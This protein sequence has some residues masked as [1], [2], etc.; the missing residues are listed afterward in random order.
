MTQETRAAT[1][2]RKWLS[3]T[4]LA[5]AGALGVAGC[6]SVPDAVNPVEWYRGASDAVGGMFGGD[7]PEAGA[8][9]GDPGTSA[10]TA[11]PNLATVPG[12]PTPSTTP[13]QREAL[14]QG[15][16]AD[17]AN[18][19]Y[20]EPVPGSQ[21]SRTAAAPQ[22]NQPQAQP[23]P[24]AAP[25]QQAASPP[26]ARSQ[27]TASTAAVPA[28]PPPATPPATPSAAVAPPAAPP[29]AVASA[30]AVRSAAANGGSG[31]WPNRPPP[32]TPGVRASTT[33]R[34]GGDEIHRSA[35]AGNQT[36]LPSH[37]PSPTAPSPSAPSVAN[38]LAERTTYDS[39][40][41]GTGSVAQTARAQPPVPPPAPSEPTPPRASEQSVIVN[42]DAIAGTVA[43]APLATS[44]GGRRYLAST[45]YFGHGSASI[46]AGERQEIARIARAAAAN[47]AAIQV[48]GHASARTADLSLRDHETANLA[49]SMKRAQTVA[50]VL[51]QS[52]MPANRVIVEAL[53][54]SQPEFYEV[55]PAGEAGNRRAEIIVIY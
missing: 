26:L 40:G 53:A 5:F 10:N 27:P 44:F 12:R 13:E 22:R 33:G 35:A 21:A 24:P 16:V 36:P 1:T 31:L 4:A 41:A 14:K 55:M 19:R 20:T 43:A 25:E 52:G 28:S 48:I 50:D 37:V 18:A 54:D 7:E 6:S 39:A 32:E 15:L 45:V 11:Y 30:P 42:E 9:A 2:R 47:G 34:V 8:T 49:M 38:R 23:K 46:T 51:I 17:R 3:T 29:A